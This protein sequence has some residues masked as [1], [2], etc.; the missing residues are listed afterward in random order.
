[1]RDVPPPDSRAAPSTTQNSC[2]VI[3]NVAFVAQEA[4]RVHAGSV[5]GSSCPHVEVS[6][7][8]TPEDRWSGQHLACL[9]QALLTFNQQQMYITISF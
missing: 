4:Q 2:P 7:S 1:M 3:S 6:L 8:K 5:L 9:W